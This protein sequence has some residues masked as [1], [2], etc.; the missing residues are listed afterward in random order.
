MNFK[1]DVSDIAL[2]NDP[3]EAICYYFQEKGHWKYSY[4]KYMEGLKKNKAKGIDS[5]YMFA[6]KLHQAMTFSN[7]IL[8]TGCGI[9]ICSYV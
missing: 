7:W 6:I 8:D 9:Y 3:K 1:K 5:S 2:V 4:P